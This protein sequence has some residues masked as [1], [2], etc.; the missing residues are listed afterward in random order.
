MLESLH[1]N[2]ARCESG[3]RVSQ[4]FDGSKH[5]PIVA[6]MFQ[7]NIVVC[8]LTPQLPHT[9]VCLL[10]TTGV[11]K[12]TQCSTLSS[13]AV[14]GSDKSKTVCLILAESHYQCLLVTP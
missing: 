3:A 13:P 5:F 14:D 6:D 2:G 9:D 4:W 8:V 12:L 1:Q 10:S 11:E 7:V